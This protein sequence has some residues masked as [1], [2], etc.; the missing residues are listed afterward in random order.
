MTYEPLTKPR[1]RVLKQKTPDP[2]QDRA[3]EITTS[4]KGVREDLVKISHLTTEENQLVTQFFGCLHAMQPMLKDSFLVSASAFSAELDKVVHARVDSAGC[5]SLTLADGRQTVLNLSEAQNRDL[6][7]VVIEAVMPQFRDLSPVSAAPESLV[8]PSELVHV[9]EVS[10]SP[11]SAPEPS[12]VTADVPVAPAEP[13]LPDLHQEAPPEPTPPTLDLEKISAVTAET[14]QYLG[15]LGNEI[16]EHV[17]VSK[18]FD[19]W[20]VNLRQVILSFESNQAIGTDS[21]FTAQ[22]T[23]IFSQIEIELAKRQALEA[24][25]EATNKILAENRH[26]LNKIDEGY[27]AQAKELVVRGKSVLDYLMCN[28]RLLEAELA[29]VTQ[30]KVSYLHPLQRLAKDQKISELMQRLDAAKKRLALA[31]GTSVVEGAKAA[32]LDA[33]Y[34]AQT[35]DLIQKRQNALGILTQEVHALEKTLVQIEKTHTLNGI[36]KAQ[37]RFEISQSCLLPKLT[38]NWLNRVAMRSRNGSRQTMR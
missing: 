16:F 20:M 23:Q 25:L 33:E 17:P 21:D 5:L 12:V 8:Q 14:L 29:E 11:L 24:D 30:I 9:S 26:L 38:S 10:A 35:H 19:D 22:C 1:S 31:V 13:A 34:T 32:N 2:L 27:A 28:V 36:R 7:M 3:K 37:Q 18:Y 4:L 6:L 15:M